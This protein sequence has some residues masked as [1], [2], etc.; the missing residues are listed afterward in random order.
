VIDDQW[1]NNYL[2]TDEIRKL[3]DQIGHFKSTESE[4]ELNKN[5]ETESVRELI[6]EI[7][8]I[9][10]MKLGLTQAEVTRTEEK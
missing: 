9:L 4:S 7:P 10:E 3:K 8:E 5:F 6:G 1:I 2:A